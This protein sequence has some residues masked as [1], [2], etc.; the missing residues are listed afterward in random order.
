MSGRQGLRE[1]WRLG[2][3]LL[4]WQLPGFI[5]Q[6]ISCWA[7][8]GNGCQE[9]GFACGRFPKG[10][11]TPCVFIHMQLRYH[12]I[13]GHWKVWDPVISSDQA[14]LMTETCNATVQRVPMNPQVEGTLQQQFFL[15]ARLS[16]PVLITDGERWSVRPI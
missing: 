15:L 2:D 13:Q 14:T 16:A 5:T 3:S 12:V 4:E 6:G 8:L 11:V 1:F 9:E 7:G 10:P